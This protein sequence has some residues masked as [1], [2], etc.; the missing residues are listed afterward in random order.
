M[1]IELSSRNVN[2]TNNTGRCA[3]N[4][5]EDQTEMMWHMKDAMRGAIVISGQD[6]HV[7]GVTRRN[8]EHENE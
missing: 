1:S 4:S 5:R 3:A 2:I 8:I 6:I 7:R